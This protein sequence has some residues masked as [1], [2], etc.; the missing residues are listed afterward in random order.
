[1]VACPNCRTQINDEQMFCRACGFRV[2]AGFQVSTQSLG[3][4]ATPRASASSSQTGGS[5]CNMNWRRFAL[6]LA[7]FLLAI[8]IGGFTTA[9]LS[10]TPVT[11]HNFTSSFSAIFAERSYIGVYLV[12]A[13]DG[14]Q[15]AVIDRVLPDSPA[16]LAGLRI[17]DR[18]LAI[19]GNSILTPGEMVARMEKIAPQTN[20]TIDVARYDNDQRDDYLDKTTYSLTTVRL[21]Q[22]HLQSNCH[23]A[24]SNEGFLGV[25]DLETV[26]GTFLE[27]VV[28]HLDEQ[29]GSTYTGVR[30]GT[31]LE[32]SAAER[33]GLQQGDIILAID[34]QLTQSQEE[35]SR[36]VRAVRPQ[37]N[38]EIYFLR[39][40][41]PNT[42]MTVMGS[43][44]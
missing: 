39:D 20:I 25:T 31:V 16:D 14:S 7:G 3:L 35:L 10:P 24:F 11:T 43:R 15:G 6:P 42:V 33:A 19:N 2:E 32:N 4:P 13:E 37:N 1:M 44:Q 12:N 38:A 34:D 5:A 18:I 17:G 30:V 41:E 8:F 29:P 9:L 22:L 40:G 26:N 27:G 23:G 36:R 21:N 28:G